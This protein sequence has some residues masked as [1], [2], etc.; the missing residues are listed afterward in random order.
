MVY[1]SKIGFAFLYLW[2]VFWALLW[3]YFGIVIFLHIHANDSL[4]C[5]PSLI[6]MI[7]IAA[8]NVYDIIDPITW[9]AEGFKYLEVWGGF[10]T[11]IICGVVVL[12][13]RI[14]AAAPAPAP[15]AAAAPEANSV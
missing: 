14:P 1:T 15:A 10:A 5:I 9:I 13:F 11:S 2:Y 4:C 8:V 6:V 12:I 7:A 3:G